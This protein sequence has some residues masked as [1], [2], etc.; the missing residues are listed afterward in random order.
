MRDWDGKKPHARVTKINW[1]A[2][3]D[4]IEKKMGLRVFVRDYEGNV[5]ASMCTTKSFIIDLIVAEVVATWKQ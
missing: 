4:K 5:L 2:V 3:I 1:N